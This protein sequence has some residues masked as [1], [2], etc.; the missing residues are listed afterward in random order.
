M[1]VQFKVEVLALGDR[2]L[3]YDVIGVFL[4]LL[5][6]LS[7]VGFEV[8]S[9]ELGGVVNQGCEEFSIQIYELS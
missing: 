7:E 9:F 1:R 2:L 8:E 5:E 4:I 3:S 6:V